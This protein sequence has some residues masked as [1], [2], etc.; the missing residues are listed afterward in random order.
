MQSSPSLSLSLTHTHTHIHTHFL[1][2]FAL[3]LCVCVCVCL[4]RRAAVRLHGPPRPRGPPLRVPQRC[5]QLFSLS[6]L[7]SPSSLCSLHILISL[8]LF[9]FSLFSTPSSLL[10][11][12]PRSIFSL[13]FSSYH[14]SRL[15]LSLFFYPNLPRFPRSHALLH[16]H[17]H[18]PL[19]S[20]PKTGAQHG[21][22]TLTGQPP[23][24]THPIPLL[25]LLPS[26]LFIDIRNEPRY[27]GLSINLA[28]SQRGISAL[29]GVG[30]DEK[31]TTS[32]EGP[33]PP[34]L[35][36]PTHTHTHTRTHMIHTHTIHTQHTHIPPP[37]A[38]PYKER[39]YGRMGCCLDVSLTGCAS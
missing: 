18:T 32:E 34:L 1:A 28:L 6:S 12:P 35:S 37:A 27:Q 9:L 36:P 39:S 38:P 16:T 2:V 3:S 7:C 33:R 31:V 10:S 20:Q 8:S 11:L 14:L 23:S 26:V 15:S 13:L 30:V 19:Q 25:L 29:A 21:R 4:G 17:T 22:E 24:Y 5:V